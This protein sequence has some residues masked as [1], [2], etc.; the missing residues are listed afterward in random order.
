M[1]TSSLP[2]YPL[3]GGWVGRECLPKS[4]IKIITE[5]GPR[6]QHSLTHLYWMFHMRMTKIINRL[7]PCTPEGPSITVICCIIV[8]RYLSYAETNGRGTQGKAQQIWKSLHRGDDIWP[9]PWAK[10]PQIKGK[11]GWRREGSK[12]IQGKGKCMCRGEK[13]MSTQCIWRL[14]G[15]WFDVLETLA[16]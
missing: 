15:L 9:R 12:D 8:K 5:C 4:L 10:I 6:T 3:G 2:A 1:S 16:V 13:H 7:W 11:I 14:T